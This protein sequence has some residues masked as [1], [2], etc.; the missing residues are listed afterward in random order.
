METLSLPV[1][2]LG[3]GW[4]TSGCTMTVGAYQRLRKPGSHVVLWRRHTGVIIPGLSEYIKC[5]LKENCKSKGKKLRC[6]VCFVYF[7][8]WGN[9]FFLFFWCALPP[10]IFFFL[11]FYLFLF[12]FCGYFRHLCILTLFH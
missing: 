1:F 2:R 7:F 12:R 10:L 6:N 8:D 11:S 4:I 5:T 9:C 3:T